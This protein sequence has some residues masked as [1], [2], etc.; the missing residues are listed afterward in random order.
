MPGPVVPLGYFTILD[1]MTMSEFERTLALQEYKKMITD[2]RTIPATLALAGPRQ[3]V[4]KKARKVS[5]YS[6][7][8]SQ[9]LKS[10]RK[11]ATLKSGKLRKGMTASKIMKKAHRNVKR[12]L[13]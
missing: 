4:R 9:E 7:A 11:S 13:K 2:P 6:K 1:F 3:R 5:R 8:L 12:R 10:L